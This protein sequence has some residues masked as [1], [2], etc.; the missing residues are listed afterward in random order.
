MSDGPSISS[1]SSDVSVSSGGYDP[2]EEHAHNSTRLTVQTVYSELKGLETD[3]ARQAAEQL[4]AVP[5]VHE[6]Y[7]KSLTLARRFS[8][9]RSWRSQVSADNYPLL[10]DD[11]S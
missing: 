10:T 8:D 7:E 5:D 11:S 6:Q 3:E 4:R 2:E 9:R 1:S